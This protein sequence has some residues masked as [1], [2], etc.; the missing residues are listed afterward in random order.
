MHTPVNTASRVS[1]IRGETQISSGKECLA[2]YLG[3][4]RYGLALKLQ[5]ASLS[6]RAEGLISDVLLLLQ[7]LPAFTVGRFRGEEDIIVPRELLA[8]EGI[9]VFHTNRGG[10][11]T[12]HGPGQLIGYPV[13]NLK[14]KGL[15]VRRYIWSLEEV[16][17]MFL[18]NIGIQGHRVAD[19]RGV[20]VGEKKICSVG[21][22][23]SRGISTHGFALNLSNDLRYFQYIRPCGLE[24]EVMTSVSELSG[25]PVEVET[26]VSNTIHCFSEVF[27]LDCRRKD[28]TCLA[29]LGALSG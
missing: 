19:H 13:L 24:G 5:Q 11:V 2:S 14:E 8:R 3:V 23:V 20:W 10:S 9:D 29:M 17:I 28:D 21:V 16:V 27:G 7:H 18:H 4:V 26:V 12:Y 25:R 6:A 15:G 1:I 22:N